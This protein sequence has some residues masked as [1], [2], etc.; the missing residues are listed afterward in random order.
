MSLVSVCL[1]EHAFILNPLHFQ[2]E[3]SEL[4]EIKFDFTQCGRLKRWFPIRG[5][6]DMTAPVMLN[7]FTVA[8]LHY[9]VLWVDE[10]N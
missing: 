9:I 10:L 7:L 3:L 4:N 8:T 2:T 6:H 5:P 1:I